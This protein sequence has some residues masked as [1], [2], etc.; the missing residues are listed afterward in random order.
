[1]QAEKWTK[2]VSSWSEGELA[3]APTY[4][5]EKGTMDTYDTSAK[6]RV[7]SWTDRVMWRTVRR[8]SLNTG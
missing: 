7:P 6:Q 1:M 3:F 4:K 2:S 8:C 5:L